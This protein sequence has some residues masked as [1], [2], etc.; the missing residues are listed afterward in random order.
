M[1]VWSQENNDVMHHTGGGRGITLISSGELHLTESVMSS[2]VSSIKLLKTE[3][4]LENCRNSSSSF[5]NC[6]NALISLFLW[7]SE[8]LRSLSH[9]TKG[10]GQGHMTP[11]PRLGW[12]GHMTHNASR[13]KSCDPSCRSCIK[14][15]DPSCRSHDPSCRSCDPSCSRSHDPVCKPSPIRSYSTDHTHLLITSACLCTMALH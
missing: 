4:F 14:S 12:S 3:A 2:T 8:S 1:G 6:S 15:H 11:C 7:A 5:L 13:S 9:L 10:E